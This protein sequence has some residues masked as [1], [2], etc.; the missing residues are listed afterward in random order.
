M[1]LLD[2][3]IAQP[4]ATP[5][6]DPHMD[7]E[8]FFH[9]EHGYLSAWQSLARHAALKAWHLAE[10]IGP[11]AGAEYLAR[12]W[13]LTGLYQ[14]SPLLISLFVRLGV[15]RRLHDAARNL[16][17]GLPIPPE[18]AAL[19]RLAEVIGSWRFP[20]ALSTAMEA[21]RFLLVSAAKSDD[22]W[23]RAISYPSTLETDISMTALVE[24]GLSREMDSRRIAAGFW[25]LFHTLV[26]A[27]KDLEADMQNPRGWAECQKTV[28]YIRKGR[29]RDKKSIEALSGSGYGLFVVE[30]SPPL[31]NSFDT[32][33]EAESRRRLTVFGLH[34]WADLIERNPVDREPPLNPLTG[35]PM[36]IEREEGHVIVRS[37]L[38]EDDPHAEEW[39]MVIDIGWL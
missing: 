19:R 3:I 5:P 39:A 6:F 14:D 18:A 20:S 37:G 11:E 22:S 34:L 24:N 33:L 35:E 31:L 23:Q 38:R 8:Y 28:M 7:P 12:A 29:M 26:Q 10:T 36:I 27:A 9:D 25:K 16:S 4:R 30:L 1:A 32:V 2:E 21:E 17:Q 15:E 13:P